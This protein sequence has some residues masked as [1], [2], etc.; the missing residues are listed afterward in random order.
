MN[1]NVIERIQN[2]LEDLDEWGRPKKKLPDCPF[3]AE[4]ELGVVYEGKILCYYCGFSLMLE[5]HFK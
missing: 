3:C 1:F 4:D 5:E 2:I